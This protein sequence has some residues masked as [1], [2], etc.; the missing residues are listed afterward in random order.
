MENDMF[1]K[2]Y[3]RAQELINELNGLQVDLQTG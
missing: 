2:D 3:G 1:L